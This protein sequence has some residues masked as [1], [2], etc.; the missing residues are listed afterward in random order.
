MS[1]KREIA[2]G[3]RVPEE[4]CRMETDLGKK[5]SRRGRT[6]GLIIFKLLATS[7]VRVEI[8]VARKQ[9][10]GRKKTI[11]QRYCFTVNFRKQ[12]SGQ[13]VVR[14]VYCTLGS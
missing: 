10:A 11:V 5:Q 9:R 12:G 6:E 14:E 13:E 2:S 1:G 7:R 3:V 8:H 4:K